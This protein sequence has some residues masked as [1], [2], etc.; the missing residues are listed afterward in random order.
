MIPVKLRI[1][2]EKN[3][4]YTFLL[5]VL[6]SFTPNA[7][8]V[9]LFHDILEDSSKVK[10]IFSISRSSFE[11]FILRELEQG[12]KA[13]AFNELSDVICNKKK[14]QK[15]FYVSFDDANSSVYSV[16]Y[17]FL[18][19]HNIPFII[20]I[21]KELVGKPNFLTEKQIK[22]LSEDDLCTVG[23]HAI[24]HK[25]FRYFSEEQ[26]KQEYAESKKYLEVLIQKE[27][28]SFAFPYGRVVECSRKSIKT[29]KDSKR[30]DFAFSAIAGTIRQKWLSGQ[31]FLPRVNVDESMV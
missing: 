12:K 3:R 4:L 29:L 22:E 11:T 9:Y 2:R 27:V 19:K 31:F 16:A 15:G 6:A 21:T 24:H 28:K 18:K 23:A 5:K 13:L 26:M 20:F 7:T 17:P 10:S 1:I 14:I 25:M 8:K 30:Y